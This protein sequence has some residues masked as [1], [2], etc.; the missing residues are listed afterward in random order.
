MSYLVENASRVKGLFI[1]HAHADHFAAVPYLL[2][3]L[4][5]PIYANRLTIEYIKEMM[6]EKEFK[7]LK[8]NISFHD[9]N[10]T[11]NIISVYFVL[12]NH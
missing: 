1:S 11:T 5:V 2:R 10:S 7:D 4:N 9:F 8:E 3:E 12:I 6:D